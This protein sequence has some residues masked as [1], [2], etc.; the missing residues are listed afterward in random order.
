VVKVVV[1]VRLQLSFTVNKF[2]FCGLCYISLQCVLS[3]R[4]T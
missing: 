1:L 4:Y 2:A 3:V